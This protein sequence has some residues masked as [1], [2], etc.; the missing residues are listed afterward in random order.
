MKK[1][2]MLVLAMTVAL[3][4]TACGGGNSGGSS[5][6][7]TAPQ[8]KTAKVYDGITESTGIHMDVEMT[9]S[10]QTVKMDF[11]IKGDK[12]YA[13]ATVDDQHVIALDDGEDFYAL[14][15]DT[16]VGYKTDD[17]TLGLEDSME[18]MADIS[19]DINKSK[20]TE[21]TKEIDG[22]TYDTEEFANEDDSAI[23]CYDGDTLCY[24]IAKNDSTET[25]M[26]V[27]AID[28]KVDESLFKVPS[29]YSITDQTKGDD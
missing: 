5:S 26:K 27:N 9:V 17:D 4:M 8:T 14:M 16:K 12:L 7:E 29:G 1:I 13:D 28:N 19:D 3:A 15:P 25:Q 18:E 20:C 11:Q 21:G 22:K 24:I 6:E 10:K 23:F 2:I